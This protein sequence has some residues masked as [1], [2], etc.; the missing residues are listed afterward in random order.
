MALSV[1]NSVGTGVSRR[2]RLGNRYTA[3]GAWLFLCGSACGSNVV[4]VGDEPGAA[5]TRDAGAIGP[6]LRV[7]SGSPDDIGAS[8]CAI[9]NLRQYR[10]VFDSDGGKLERR[11]YSMRADG[12]ELQALTPVDELAREPAVSPDGTQLA[13][14]TPE[15]IKLLDLGTGQSELL[16]PEADQP[17]WSPDG[18]RLAY[19]IGLEPNTALVVLLLSDRASE[20]HYLSGYLASSPGWSPDG[21]SVVYASAREGVDPIPQLRSHT[22]GTFEERLLAPGATIR[23]NHPTVSLD[24]IWVAAAFQCAGTTHSSLWTSPFAVTTPA[25]EGRRVTRAD[26]A[27]ATNPEWGPGVLIAY[28]RSEPPRDVAIIAADTGDECVIER[29]GDDRNPSWVPDL[30]RSPE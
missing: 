19:R 27:T 30:F 4:D 26:A 1:S 16:V 17:A 13:Y 23:Q 14:T 21:L 25:C 24:G 2:A 20:A 28:E 29:L 9:E 8:K 11:I 12:S 3:Y 6:T 18:T 7:D 22:L 5:D 15:G 10:L